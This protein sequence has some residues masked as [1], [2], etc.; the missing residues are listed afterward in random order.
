MSDSL[1]ISDGIELLGGGVPC[2]LPQCQNAAG[3]GTQFSLSPGYDQGAPLPITDA[4]VENILDGE[5]VLGT[6]HGN[7]VLT[8]PIVLVAPDYPTLAASREYLLALIDA[9][10]FRIRWT[11]DNYSNG[12]ASAP[13]ITNGSFEAG[14]TGWTTYDSAAFT[15]SSTQAHSGTFSGRL[16][17]NGSIANPGVFTADTPIT[18]GQGAGFSI[19]ASPTSDWSVSFF[20][21]FKD[22]SHTL[23]G[24]ATITNTVQLLAADGFQQISVAGIAP[25]NA[26]YALFVIQMN[27]TPT[28]A[29][30]L[31][32]D[33]GVNASAQDF[34]DYL[35]QPMVYNCYRANQ[36]TLTYSSRRDRQNFVGILSI[37]IPAAPFGRSQEPLTITVQ[38]PLQGTGSAPVS[39]VVIETFQSGFPSMWRSLGASKVGGVS[40][41]Y[42][43]YTRNNNQAFY[44]KSGL[45]LNLTGEAYLAHWLGLSAD[46]SVWGWNYLWGTT[47][48]EALH[49]IYTLT[50]NAGHTLSFSKT[51]Y[52]RA[53]MKLS[54]PRWQ[55]C[56][57]PLPASANFVWT[58]VTAWSITITNWKAAKK[59]RY[60][61][62]TLDQ[63]VASPTAN[64][65]VAAIRGAMYQISLIGSARS[66]INVQVQ[67]PQGTGTPITVAYGVPGV[68]QWPAPFGVSSVSVFNTGPGGKGGNS[69]NSN[70]CAGGA[71]GGSTALNAAV[72]VTAGNTYTVTVTAGGSVTPTTFVGD[73][74]TVTAPAGLNGGNALT[75]NS[76][77]TAGAAPSAGTGGHAGGAGAAGVG[78]SGGHSG[79]GGSSA[80]TSAAGNAA[81]GASGGAAVTGGGKGASGG[82]LPGNYGGLDGSFPGGAGSGSSTGTGGTFHRGGFGGNGQVLLTYTPV[83]PPFQT[84]L[85]HVPSIDTPL[86]L[87]PLVNVG[88]GG[89]VPDGNTEYAVTSNDPAGNARFQGTYSVLAVNFA[90]TT[91]SV[92]RTIT[93][94][95]NQYAYPGAVPT[96]VNVQTTIIPNNLPL[97]NGFLTIGEISLPI[98]DLAPDNFL[99]YFTINVTSSLTADR[100]LDVIFVDTKGQLVLMSTPQLYTTVYVDEPSSL[101]D[102]GRVLGTNADRDSAQSVLGYC[103][104]SGGPLLLQAGDNN[105]TAYCVEGAPSLVVIATPSWFSDRYA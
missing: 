9:E 1:T 69:Q 60:T 84:M 56:S 97:L 43:G 16:V 74:V 86:S 59:L 50:D 6:R 31:Y 80:G 36:S 2:T 99:A 38:S 28:S 77:G 94:T 22:A 25:A 30:F 45:S 96:S 90:W 58:N 68:Y 89:D 66:P 39:P 21:Q 91:P 47:R 33:D 93:I 8:L 62:P 102:I 73:S 101:R 7:R 34:T 13:C 46:P 4:T 14:V 85:L 87:N 15:Q 64:N 49:L 67:Q 42:T 40:A 37:S 53:S 20:V 55:Y 105:L 78:G 82:T 92:S 57:V 48:K 104:V 27:A 29:N 65:P 63:L 35:A 23:I 32:L 11:R 44:S 100:F 12:S 71:S 41:Q 83:F 5:R 79:G 24:S 98:L 72:G 51:Y 88:G 10:E 19:W 61:V 103:L 70:A 95:V 26:A 3:V 18:P 76:S 52:V 75:T 17:G 54:A 81:S